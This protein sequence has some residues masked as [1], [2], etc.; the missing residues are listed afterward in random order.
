MKVLSLG[1]G[2]QS[3][4]LL[5]KACRGELEMPDVAIFV[6]LGWELPA[7]YDWLDRVLIP[8]SEKAGLDLRI[9]RPANIREDLIRE[10]GKRIMAPLFVRRPDGKRGQLQHQ[11]SRQLKMK[12]VMREARKLMGAGSRGQ[13]PPHLFLE[14][15]LGISTDE[16]GRIRGD[17]PKRTSWRYPL[18]EAGLSRSDC[19]TWLVDSG[20][21][22]A[23]RS[24]CVGCPFRAQVSWV[25]LKS[26]SPEVFA[27]AVEVDRLVRD[28]WR[29]RGEVFLH[30]SLRPLDEAVHDPAPSLFDDFE[31]ECSGMCGV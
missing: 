11:C 22:L 27:D 10:D 26:K 4:T 25:E 9:V 24:S 8:E 21:G 30:G 31:Y 23:P 2:V 19:E 13:L 6:D 3:S 18:I 1:A 20:F 5:L 15:W 12:P 28:K 14:V 29:D 16:T 7:T 17:A